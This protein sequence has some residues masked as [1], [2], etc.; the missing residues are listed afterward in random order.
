M[1]CTGNCAFLGV[2]DFNDTS[3]AN[4]SLRNLLVV[5]ADSSG[6]YKKSPLSG[7]I[8]KKNINLPRKD[9]SQEPDFLSESSPICTKIGCRDG[10]FSTRYLLHDR[11]NH[12]K[13]E[14]VA[15]LRRVVL[16]NVHDN[17]QSTEL[18]EFTGKTVTEKAV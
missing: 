11:F 1:K 14:K 6:N 7:G 5:S 17:Q 4:S 2:H 18:G 3:F 9:S 8:R 10:A 12:G 16:R 13:L 15:G